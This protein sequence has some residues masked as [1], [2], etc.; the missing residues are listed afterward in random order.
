[1]VGV[2][3]LVTVAT[4]CCHRSFGL[5][6]LHLQLLQLL[7]MGQ[8]IVL[9]SAFEELNLLPNGLFFLLGLVKIKSF[10]ILSK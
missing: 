10:Q 2:S 9:F 1:M 5:V 3:G 8:C 4:P 6:L 7:E